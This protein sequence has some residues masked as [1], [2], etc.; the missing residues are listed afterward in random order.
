MDDHK[1][2]G[3][4]IKITKNGPYLVSGHVPLDRQKIVYD[5]DKYLLA[6]QKENDYPA[7]EKYLLCRC[8]H[9]ADKPYCDNTHIKINFIGAE[10]AEDRPFL[11]GVE[12]TDGPDITLIDQPKL[13]ASAH[14]CTRAGGTWE[15]TRHSKD[16]ESKK[17]AIKETA[18]CPAGRLVM[19]NKAT[20][21]MYEPVFEPSISIIEDE[22]SGVDGPIWVKAG[23]PIESADGKIYENRNRVTLCRCGASRN[24]PFCDGSHLGIGIQK[25]KS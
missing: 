21:E 5:K 16:P 25:S 24:K 14:F 20:G 6:Y 18:D 10:T 2:S 22:V 4:K 12:K 13:C 23:I 8:G 7:R 1:I 3:F 17:L 15:L 11:A 19:T 9:S